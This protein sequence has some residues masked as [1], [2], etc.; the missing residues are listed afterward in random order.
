MA[1]D[2]TVKI[3]TELD[4]D[5][6]QK[7]LSSFNDIAKKGFTGIATAA[8]IG[9]AAIT[10]V[11]GAMTAGAVA[12]VKYNATI[13]QYQTSFEVMTG[14]AEKAVKIVEN[15]KK[16]GAETPFELTDL[17]DTTQLLMNYGLQAEDAQDKLMMLGDISQGSAD[18]MKSISMAYGQMSSA[19]KVSLED[20]KQMIE[21]G[22]NPLQEISQSTGESMASLYD[23]ISK[24]TISVDEITASMERSTSAGGKYFQSM[25]KQ[26]EGFNGQIST[27]KDNANQLIGEV[28]EPISEK[29]TKEL[30]PNAISTIDEMSASFKKDGINGLVEASGK[31]FADITA[32]AADQ[33]PVMVDTAVKFIG[34]FFKGI[35]NNKNQ[36]LDSAKEMAS[37][38]IDGLADLLPSG[39][40]STVKQTIKDLETSIKS[41][42]L[43]NGIKTITNAFENLGDASLELAKVVLPML[44]KTVDVCADNIDILV[45]SAVA[46][47]AAM[48][49]YKVV[50]SVTDSVASMSK[51]FTAATGILDAY[52][53]K[54]TAAATI[55][56]LANGEFTVG[57]TVI[58]G[59]SGRIGIATT[60]QGLWNAVMTANPIGLV[61]TAVAALAA[62]LIAYNLLQDKTT[63]DEEKLNKAMEQSNAQ[64]EKAAESAS[65]FYSGIEKAGSIF[66]NFNE[67]I[68]V[69]GEKQQELSDKMDA[70]QSEITT[71]ASTATEERRA[72]TQAEISRLDELF[73]KMRDIAQQELDMQ[74]KYQEAVTAQAQILAAS[75]SGTIAEYESYAQT[76]LNSAN[77]TKQAVIDKANEQYTEETAL[78]QQKYG[79]QAN[80]QNA[81]Y[82]AELTAAEE[83]KNTAIQKAGEE[84][85]STY[86]IV[87]QGYQDRLGSTLNYINN[88]ALLN[89]QE[90]DEKTL[91]NNQ[92]KKI[93]DDY[94]KAL[95]DN[96][97][98]VETAWYNHETAT[99]N[100]E[101]KH[102]STMK[103]IQKGKTKS[104]SD[105]EAAQLGVWLAMVADTELH[106]GKISDE[107]KK[108]ADNVIDNLDDL[109]DG[110]REVMKNAMTPMLEEMEKAAPSILN[111]AWDLGT[112]F[113]SR[114]K[115]ALDEHSPSKKTRKVFRFAMQ[116]A[117]LGIDDEEENVL[118]RADA[119]SG[120]MLARLADINTSEIASRLRGAVDIINAKVADGVSQNAQVNN[121]Y[122]T[123]NNS[124]TTNYIFN[125]PVETPD[126]TARAIRKADT[127][128]LAGA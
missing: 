92:K 111:K 40:K 102:A 65:S 79:D 84:S 18:K 17:A 114:L 113:V 50:T 95:E 4:T 100:L 82:V 64:Y 103:E 41:G 125:Q 105:E 30:L 33:A 38:F 88:M 34:S 118:S 57:Q 116:G 42:G 83:K 101:T 112:S 58:A 43:K 87:E 1:N 74:T 13:E 39:I 77:E 52:M 29:M 37:T 81:A 123:S 124:N 73:A 107:T 121:A 3:G 66:D 28:V 47:F 119:L 19:G 109:P 76:L 25:Q 96:Q 98:S 8:K 106:G 24:G 85:A 54:N 126:E 104:M 99:Q 115:Q 31:A 108:M 67:S 16:V 48:K 53:M 12:G 27:I 7:G 35:Q 46:L 14:S 128:G 2:G 70:V 36:I 44:T 63:S 62:G 117:A 5:G 120:D 97:S 90:A 49:G 9:F 10:A 56:A 60:A 32:L 26:S 6:V 20:V 21:A 110:T 94:Y 80:M 86:S 93:D 59:L 61:V 71:I 91:Y 55:Q 72:L 22:F 23:R 68:I 122:N 11:T 127:F 51:A 15:L 45:P 75:H 78:L 89:Q 69:S